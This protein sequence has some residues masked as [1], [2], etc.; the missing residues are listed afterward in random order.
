MLGTSGRESKVLSNTVFASYMRRHH[1]SWHA[2]ARQKGIAVRDSD[3]ILVSG[4]VKTSDWAL[5][6]VI[7]YGRLH[8]ISFSAGVSGFASATFRVVSQLNAQASIEQRRGPSRTQHVEPEGADAKDQCVFLRY[9]KQKTRLLGSSKI[10]SLPLDLSGSDDGTEDGRK[11]DI[12]DNRM[13][14]RSSVLSVQR[15]LGGGQSLDRS[16]GEVKEKDEEAN[17][18]ASLSVEEVPI[19]TAV[20]SRFHK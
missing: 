4:W 18:P 14:G 5:A 11:S 17:M 20:W 12:Q 13:F 6:A 10:V 8:D 1:T 2:F 15:F 9:Y 16:S 19:Q 7:S 3:I